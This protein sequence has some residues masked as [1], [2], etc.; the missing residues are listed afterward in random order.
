MK[1]LKAI[2]QVSN[3]Q[4]ANV[5]YRG[6]FPIIIGKAGR[7]SYKESFNTTGYISLTPVFVEKLG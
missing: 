3:M 1:K 6:R 5:T 7:G 2:Q 4:R